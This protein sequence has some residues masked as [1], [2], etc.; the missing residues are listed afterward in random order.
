MTTA[1][2]KASTNTMIFPPQSPRK[3][4]SIMIPLSF[5]P[6]LALGLPVFGSPTVQSRADNDGIH[7]AVSPVCGSATGGVAV[8]HN[9]GIPALSQFK[10]I[11]AFGVSMTS[12]D[13]S[14]YPDL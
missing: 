14:S 12:T 11:V 7:L 6:V 1:A 4:Y 8:D 3:S 5:L 10:T 13:S 9:N 2:Y